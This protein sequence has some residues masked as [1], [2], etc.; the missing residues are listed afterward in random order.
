MNDEQWAPVRRRAM[1][2]GT[3]QAYL[4]TCRPDGLDSSEKVG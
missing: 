1:S 4:W 3:R 2:Y